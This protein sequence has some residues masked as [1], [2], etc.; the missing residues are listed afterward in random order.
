VGGTFPAL[1]R[2]IADRYRPCAELPS[3]PLATGY[4]PGVPR[5]AGKVQRIY[6]LNRGPAL[7]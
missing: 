7:R 3:P 6:V 5:G 1:D 2:V 4:I